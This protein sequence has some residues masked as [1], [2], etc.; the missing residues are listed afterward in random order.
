MRKTSISN[1][2]HSKVP[3]DFQHPSLAAP[4]APGTPD[5]AIGRPAQ[6]KACAEGFPDARDSRETT[7]RDWYHMLCSIL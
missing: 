4:G 7:R 1:P 3:N 5:P 2:Q 6:A